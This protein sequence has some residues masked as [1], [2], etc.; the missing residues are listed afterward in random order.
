[1][2]IGWSWGYTNLIQTTETDRKD[3]FPNKNQIFF[4]RGSRN[5]LRVD[6]NTRCPL[7]TFPCYMLPT[8]FFK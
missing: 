8:M 7:R 1:M 3:W 6:K 2:P 4:I 5:G